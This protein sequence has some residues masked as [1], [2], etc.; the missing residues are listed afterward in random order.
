MNK[1]FLLH[2][3]TIHIVQE[4]LYKLNKKYHIYYIHIYVYL[5]IVHTLEFYPEN[6]TLQTYIIKLI[7][8][9]YKI[10]IKFFLVVDVAI[11]Y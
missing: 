11:K 1:V 9:S 6:P 8:Y 3:P 2:F 5:S 4:Q 7:Y 10:G